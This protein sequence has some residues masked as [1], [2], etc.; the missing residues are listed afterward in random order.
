MEL[1][2]QHN[3]AENES[4][5]LSWCTESALSRT[6]VPWGDC[7][8][9]ELLS[10]HK[11]VV[12]VY[13]PEEAILSGRGCEITNNFSGNVLNGEG[14]LGRSS[15]GPR[16]YESRESLAQR[17]TDQHTSGWCLRGNLELI[18]QGLALRWEAGGQGNS[19]PWVPHSL[20]VQGVLY[21]WLHCESERPSADNKSEG[22][23]SPLHHPSSDFIFPRHFFFS[24]FF[25]CEGLHLLYRAMFVLKKWNVNWFKSPQLPIHSQKILILVLAS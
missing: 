17:L 10:K 16:A 11:R 18:Q 6:G 13:K 23:L 8:L 3:R 22:C 21:H 1:L 9:G 19:S 2:V 4:Q 20:D 12:K 15:N 14:S 24:S 7:F 25:C 5:Q